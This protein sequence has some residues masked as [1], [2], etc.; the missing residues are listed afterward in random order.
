MQENELKIRSKLALV[1]NGLYIVR[2]AN[3]AA[4]EGVSCVTL[5]NSPIGRG[6]IDFFPAEGVTRNT[7][8]KPGDCIVIRVKGEKTGLLI[9][10]F[11]TSSQAAPIELR[12][13]RIENTEAPVPPPAENAVSRQAQ[14]LLQSQKINCVLSGH[15][16]GIGDT[17]ATNGWLG[18]PAASLKRIEGFSV[19]VPSLPEGLIL[20]YS[21]RTGKNA[22]P[23]I[24]TTGRFVGTRRQAKPITAVAFALSGE[25]ANQF[26]L[27]GHVVFAA[28]PPLP[29]VSGQEL[30]GPTG[31][32]QLV[33]MQL[34]IRPKVSLQSPAPTS[35]WED[36][37][38]THIFKD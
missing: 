32:E 38:R 1:E 9:T 27:I 19:N 30:S 23:Q 25:R 29:L 34:E 35:P 10:E 24:G 26:E 7:L 20:A 18:A 16:E 31:T 33:A 17:T 4:P 36:Q 14:A 37:S 12:I 6:I 22:E 5:N 13:D 15:I 28:T 2:Y 21:C 8:T 11:A 3:R